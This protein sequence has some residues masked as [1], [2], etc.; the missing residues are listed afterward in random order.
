MAPGPRLLLI[1]CRFLVSPYFL[2]L[3]GIPRSLTEASFFLSPRR[4]L[5]VRSP[6]G[7]ALTSVH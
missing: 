5:F 3:V 6:K 4:L 2:V 1:S 7:K